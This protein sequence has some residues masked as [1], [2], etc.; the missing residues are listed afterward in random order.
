MPCSGSFPP[1]Q[2]RY[3]NCWPGFAWFSAEGTRYEKDDQLRCQG[4][5]R[6]WSDGFADNHSN[7]YYTAIHTRSPLW[8]RCNHSNSF[9]AWYSLFSTAFSYRVGIY[10]PEN[11]A[12]G[13]LSGS[14]NYRVKHHHVMKSDSTYGSTLRW[15]EEET[16]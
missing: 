14:G 1:G 3:I 11:R 13:G 15:R 2:F 7:R 12:R 10:Q 5:S 8:S 6:G 4:K 16:W 9:K